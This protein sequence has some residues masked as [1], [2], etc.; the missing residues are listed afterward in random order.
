MNAERER[1]DN[2]KHTDDPPADDNV[3]TN[4]FCIDSAPTVDAHDI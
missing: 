3:V 1:K 2:R 4:V